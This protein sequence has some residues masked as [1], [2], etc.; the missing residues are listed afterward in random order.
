MVTLH[1]G[2]GTIEIAAGQVLSFELEESLPQDAKTPKPIAMP[3]TPLATPD[4]PPSSLSP[5]Q[6]ADAAADKYGLPRQLVRSVMKAE[7]GFQPEAI[8]PKGAVGLMQLMPGTA[9]TL[10]ADPWI[11]AQNVD[12]GT[13]YLRDLLERYNGGLRHALAA[14]NAGPG[15]VD[16]YRGVPPFP[17]TVNYVQRVEREWKK[18]E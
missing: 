12:A 15:A 10:D 2:S 1:V 18:A 11:P 7:S 4:T 17:E 6:M 3:V 14:Y 9:E 16:K 5:Q 13:K 8:S